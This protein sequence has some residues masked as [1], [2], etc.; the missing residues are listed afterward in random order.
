VGVERLG[1]R[2]A[3]LPVRRRRRPRGARR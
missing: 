3:G 2:S 1:R